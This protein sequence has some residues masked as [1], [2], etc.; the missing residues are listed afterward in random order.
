MAAGRWDRSDP[1]RFLILPGYGITIEKPFTAIGAKG[2]REGDVNVSLTIYWR[3]RAK[4]GEIP[5]C[6]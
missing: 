2:P 3:E 6:W 4:I 5:R 1:G